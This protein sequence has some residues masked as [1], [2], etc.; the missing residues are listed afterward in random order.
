MLRMLRCSSATSLRRIDSCIAAKS[1][2]TA[3]RCSCSLGR[4]SAGMSVSGEGPAADGLA[5]GALG[6]CGVARR[7]FHRCRASAPVDA[8]RSAPPGATSASA[9]PSEAWA[10][11]RAVVAVAAASAGCAAA[12]AS[13]AWRASRNATKSSWIE[14]TGL[15]AAG[16]K[17]AASESEWPKAET[18]TT[19]VLWRREE[20]HRSKA[21]APSA[22]NPGLELPEPTR[23]DPST[24][25]QGVHTRSNT[26]RVGKAS[27]IAKAG[28]P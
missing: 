18:S 24:R 25:E 7:W 8:A 23:E 21:S 9:R 4:G 22:T 10:P 26:A 28:R 11:R 16:T 3:A 17:S 1:V 20:D 12:A 13:S 15:G 27:A 2:L 6:I 14:C 5:R 19:G